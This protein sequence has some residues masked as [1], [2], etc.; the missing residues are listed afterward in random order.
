[1]TFNLGKMINSETTEIEQQELRSDY[2][3]LNLKT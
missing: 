1:M 3:F 2:I